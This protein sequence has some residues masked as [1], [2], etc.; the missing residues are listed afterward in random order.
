MVFPEHLTKAFHEELLQKREELLGKG[1]NPYPYSFPFTHT[2]KEIQ[3][4]AE[5]LL[6]KD[7][8]KVAGRVTAMRRQGKKVFFVDVEDFDGHIQ[9]Y[10]RES[11][12]T[13]PAWETVLM[14]DM[15]DWIGVT[16]KVFKT[17]T[18]ELTVWAK[19]FTLLCKSV[20]RVP[21]GKTKGEKTYYQL[22]DAEMVYRQRYL[23]WITNKSARQVMVARAKAITEVRKFMES[24]GF[25]EVLTPTIELIY[26]GAAAR[27]FETNIH[28]LSDQKAYLRISPELALKKFIVGGFPKVYTICQNFRN[29]GIDRLHNPEF[30]MMEWYEILTDYNYQMK[31]FEE[32][33]ATVVEKVTGSPKLNYQGTDLDFTP[34]WKRI[35]MYE[36]LEQIG[37]VDVTKLSDEDLVK[38][39]KELDPKWAIPQPFSRGHLVAFLFETLCE[40][41]LIQPT[42]VYDYPVEISP[43]TKLKRGNP[44]L[45]ERFEP[46]VMGVEI[47]NAYS[48]LTDPVEQYE[49]LRAQ[50]QYDEDSMKK[51]GAVHHPVDTNFV[52]AIGFGMPPTGG[53]GLGID[54]LIM[55][56]TNQPTLRDIIPFPML[57]P[58]GEESP[59]A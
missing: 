42:I 11:D 32:L 56:V 26:G 31:Q 12:L 37:N 29:E 52:D 36:A 13:A 55:F 39:V 20:I 19:D 30:T 28:A 58:Q 25:L 8:V 14:L 18:G 1:T 33:V 5:K 15:G 27:P 3:E 38:K 34:P 21:F 45:V 46:Y 22:S 7:D 59:Q 2:L 48:E 51:D 57:R 44:A 49:R 41:K 50:R 17:K 23:F 53:V 47:G 54:R 6:E 24:R 9:A 35:T 4:Q 16:G 40:K 10:L 43:L